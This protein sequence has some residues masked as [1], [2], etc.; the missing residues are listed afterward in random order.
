MGKYGLGE[1]TEKDILKSSMILCNSTVLGKLLNC[2]DKEFTHH[3]DDN[4]DVGEW[5]IELS[6]VIYQ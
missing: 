4:H 2:L 6:F 3:A 5:F 1:T